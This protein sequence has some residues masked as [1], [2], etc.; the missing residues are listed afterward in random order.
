M[1]AGDPTL[2]PLRRSLVMDKADGAAAALTNRRAV[3]LV[4]RLQR[5]E[6]L[7]RGVAELLSA[8]SPVP[9]Q[10]AQLR[11]FCSDLAKLLAAV[12]GSSAVHGLPTDVK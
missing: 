9:R 12:R 1:F 10:N 3:E 4:E 7:E 2:E 8:N 11:R 5:L 6:Q